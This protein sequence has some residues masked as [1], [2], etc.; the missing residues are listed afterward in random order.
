MARRHVFR[1][2]RLCLR[3]QRIELDE[4]ITSNTGVRCAT[5]RILVDEILDHLTLKDITEVDHI[6]GNAEHI[7]HA[8]CVFHRTECAA[9]IFAL[10]DIETLALWPYV[11]GNPN[12]FVARAHEER[13]GDRAVDAPAH[14][15]EDGMCHAILHAP[16]F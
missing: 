15:N 10:D 12:Y 8:T 11:E 4:L 16:L 6:M 9:G 3:E 7:A 1:S 5:E 13:S 14:A 2:Q